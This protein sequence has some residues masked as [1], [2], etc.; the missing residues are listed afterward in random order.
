MAPPPPPTVTTVLK[1]PE[2]GSGKELGPLLSLVLPAVFG[3]PLLSLV[4]PALLLG[5]RYLA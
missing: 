5:R 4:L 3:L 2:Y 1:D